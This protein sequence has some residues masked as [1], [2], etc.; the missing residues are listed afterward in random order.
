MTYHMQNLIPLYQRPNVEINSHVIFLGTFDD[1]DYWM[2]QTS[3]I[4]C[5]VS[6][7]IKRM[8]NVW[9][10]EIITKKARLE[11]FSMYSF[12]KESKSL[13]F[14]KRGKYIGDLE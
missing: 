4:P 9:E 5:G 13:W 6:I 1:C 7:G 14:D 3:G 10:S 11:T 8:H 2:Y 12:F